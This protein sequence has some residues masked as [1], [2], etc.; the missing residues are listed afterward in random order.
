M[1]TFG[2]LATSAILFLGMLLLLELGRRRGLRMAALRGQ[3]RGI[4]VVEGAIFS[5]LGLLLAF[6]FNSAMTRW[7]T[8]R[9]LVVDES[10][11]IGTAYLRLDVL[12]P[13][14]RSELQDR[15][16]AYV[17]ARIAVYDVL[18]REHV[19]TMELAR[20]DSLQAGIWDLAVKACAGDSAYKAILL[21]PALNDMIDLTTTRT[22][23]AR[24]HT[25]PV[26][27]LLIV[28]LA[29]AGAWAAGQAMADASGPSWFHMVGFAL[30][31][32][33]AFYVTL[34]LE[35]PRE[36]FIRLD[37]VDEALADLLMDM[38]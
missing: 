7:D 1:F 9:D 6:T 33:A 32:T 4:A 29:L 12:K 27:Y 5:L 30:L 14:Q 2:I 19:P 15:F 35:F 28:V 8:R 38:R 10:N 13:Q 3:V 20:A 18:R 11:A 21:L 16:R 26:I 22:I 31:T 37:A 24:T 23:A 25:P 36:G 34:E 17:A